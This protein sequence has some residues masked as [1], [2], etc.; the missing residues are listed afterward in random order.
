[1][2]AIKENITCE[3]NVIESDGYHVCCRCGLIIDDLVTVPPSNDMY[4]NDYY[5]KNDKKNFKNFQEIDELESRN[6]ITNNI[7][8]NAKEYVRSWYKKKYLYINIIMLT[9]FTSQHVKIIFL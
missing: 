8:Q 2:S 1:M 5:N 7:S 3:H 4:E 9:Q 6:L